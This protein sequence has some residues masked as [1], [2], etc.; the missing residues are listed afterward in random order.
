[1]GGGRQIFMLVLD[2]ILQLNYS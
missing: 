2:I 1:M